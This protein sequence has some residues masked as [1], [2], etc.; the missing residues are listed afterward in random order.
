MFH[1]N[2][3]PLGQ[4]KC[5]GMCIFDATHGSLRLTQRLAESF[6]QVVENA[7]SMARSQSNDEIA[8]ELEA[9]REGAST[10]QPVAAGPT[11]DTAAGLDGEWAVLIADGGTAMLSTDLST[12]EVTVL[13]HRY[14]P[15]GLLYDLEPEQPGVSWRV[16]ARDVRPIYGKSPL[17]R[18]N[19]VTGETEA[20]VAGQ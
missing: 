16:I 15:L 2:S 9:L 19:L 7:I 13:G 1:S 4:E 20:V 3:S 8:N 14:T 17:V 10:L 11:A 12:R 18:V 5:Q 6:D